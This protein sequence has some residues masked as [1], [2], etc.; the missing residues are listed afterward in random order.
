M[1][2]LQNMKLNSKP[3]YQLAEL[4][5]NQ[6]APR[7]NKPEQVKPSSDNEAPCCQGT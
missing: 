5:G 7:D 6:E 2:H 1:S 4:A 3:D